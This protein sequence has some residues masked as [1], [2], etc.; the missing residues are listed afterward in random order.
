MTTAIGTSTGTVQGAVV[1]K[2]R[3]N[4]QFMAIAQGLGI[5]DQASVPVGQALPYCT[6]GDAVETPA[7][8]MG[9]VSA[10]GYECITTIHA[11]SQSRGFKSV[12]AMIGVITTLLTDRQP[13]ALSGGQTHTGTWSLGSTAMEDPDGVTQHTV[14][15]YLFR[16]REDL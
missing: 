5:F 3:A 2:I 10:R 1:A 9:T 8:C 12:Q 11:W 14:A 7:N 13:L 6:I 4:A 16:V 15:R